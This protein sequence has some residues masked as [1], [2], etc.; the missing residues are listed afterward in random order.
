MS[1]SV[2]VEKIQELVG[3][4]LGI[5]SVKADDDLMADLGVESVDF[6][7]LVGVLEESFDIKVSSQELETLKTVRDL[8]TLLLGK[9]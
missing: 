5:R 7:N 1:T 3:R 9:V 8:H 4:Q 2:S 6:L